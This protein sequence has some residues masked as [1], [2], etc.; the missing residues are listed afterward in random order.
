[1]AALAVV[2]GHIYGSS[3]G[4][5]PAAYDSFWHR[6]LLGGGFGVYLFFCLSGYLLYLPWAR[7]HFGSGRPVDVARYAR[8]RALRILPLYYVVAIVYLIVA[9]GLPSR[10]AP[11]FDWAAFLLFG[12]NFFRR[13]LGPIDGPMWSLV[14]ELMFYVLLPFLAAAIGRL[15]GHSVRRAAGWLVALAVASGLLRWV[16]YLHPAN[17]SPLI[18]YNLPATLFFFLPG[19]LLAL[20]KVA[21]EEHP[22][23]APPRLLASSWLW[24][25]GSAT[26]WA[27]VFYRYEWDPLCGLAALLLL[28][29]CVL[30][31]RA[32]MPVR[33]L[34]WRPLA[35]LG[36]ASYSLYLW[37]FPIVNVLGGKH[38]GGYVGHLVT[39]GPLCI[40]VAV[41]SYR[42]IEAPFLK[43]R[44][45]WG[46][47]AAG[48]EGP[49]PAR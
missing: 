42:V 41:I 22:G 19:M 49:A 7:Q 11:L 32:S 34:G 2:E 21:T 45:R 43:L 24:V 17:P 3:V 28:G 36:T 13:T 38:L 33:V 44:T 29:A 26:C 30:P 8:N 27:V 14:V 16:L 39:V 12:E 1:V 5:G 47:T 23:W 25:L 4:Y 18:R 9:Q 40:L 37:H 20:G 15:A 35:A 10:P 31:L 46:D 6:T 48:H